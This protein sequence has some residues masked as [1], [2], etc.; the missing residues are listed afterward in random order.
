[1]EGAAALL[2]AVAKA[3]GLYSVVAVGYELLG[4]PIVV[5]D[6]SWKAIAIAADEK[7]S[8]DKGYN[9]FLTQGALSLDTVTFDIKD[10]LTNRIE[11][12]EKP[13]RYQGANMKYARLLGRILAG[14]RPVATVSVIE[15]NHPFS[16]KD[17]EIVEMLCDA[18]SAEMQKNKFLHYTRGLLYEELIVE[19]LESG[20][21][22]ANLVS[23]RIKA[24]GLGMKKFLYVITV[25]IKGFDI[26]KFSLS[27]MR[28]YIEKM[29]SGSKALIYNDYIVVVTSCSRENNL[30]EADTNTLDEFL[31]EYNMRAGISRSFLRL[32]DM[33]EHYRQSLEALNIG[34]RMNTDECLYSYE[35]YAVYHIA[36]V[37]S[38]YAG[39]RQFCQPKLYELL[40]YDKEHNTSFT[41]SLY[42]YLKHSRNITE[43]AKALHLHRNSMIYHLKRIEEILGFPLSESNTLLHIELSFRFME[44]EML[45]F[46]ANDG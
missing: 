35:D 22:N 40:E 13:F 25:D 4:N 11:R 41:N 31:R 19:L 38:Q 23:E 29:I 7:E 8:E 46:P 20:G 6:K 39:L 34:M 17:F 43:T 32:E 28:D 36:K 45:P 18:V 2:S 5:S 14:N 12:S 24:L 27:Y 30:L 16:D 42:A 44:Y 9:E 26:E 1:M 33:G 3:R 15:V 37:C 10:K 21:D